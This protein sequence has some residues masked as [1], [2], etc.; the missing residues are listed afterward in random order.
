MTEPSKVKLYLF[1][2]DRGGRHTP[3]FPGYRPELVPKGSKQRFKVLVDG[4][5]Q[6][7][8]GQSSTV[9]VRLLDNASYTLRKGDQFTILEDGSADLRELVE[10][11]K[12]ENPDADLAALGLDG[13]GLHFVGEVE[14]L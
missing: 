1:P 10:L 2:T 9:N 4:Y 11:A 14:I 6:L 12:L 7:W 13:D 5:E 3:V 8:P